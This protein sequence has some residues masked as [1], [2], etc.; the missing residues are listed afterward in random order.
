MIESFDFSHQTSNLSYVCSPFHAIPM[1]LFIGI[2]LIGI[3]S[4]AAHG[5][6]SRGC[7]TAL[8]SYYMWQFSNLT[9]VYQ[10]TQVPIPSILS[11]NPNIPNQDSVQ[12]FSRVNVPFRCDCL[13]NG[14]FLGH[15]FKFT[16]FPGVTYLTIAQ[17]YYSNLTTPE[18]LQN[19]NT[20]PATNIPDTGVTV[21]VAVNCSCGDEN[22]SK[23]YGLFVTYPLREGQTL[24][25]VATENNLPTELVRSYNPSADF[26]AGSGLVYLPGKGGNIY[27]LFLFLFFT[28]CF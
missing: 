14:E 6:C 22:V 5:R 26:S 28:F 16:T 15:V 18:F 19:T 3:F 9:F 12:A 17:E 13:N 27:M 4:G 25:S 11:Y 7:D 2:L 21:D 20:Y 1:K 10:M 24:E 23:R 8:A